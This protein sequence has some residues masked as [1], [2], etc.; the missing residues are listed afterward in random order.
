MITAANQANENQIVINQL[1]IDNTISILKKEYAKECKYMFENDMQY[2]DDEFDEPEFLTLFYAQYPKTVDYFY[3]KIS[4]ELDLYNPLVIDYV[5]WVFSEDKK[6]VEILGH[7]NKVLEYKKSIEELEK[8]KTILP[9]TKVARYKPGFFVL[10]TVGVENR[11]Y[12]GDVNQP[13]IDRVRINT[14]QNIERVTFND[15]YKE[16]LEEELAIKINVDSKFVPLILNGYIEPENI[17][18]VVLEFALQGKSYQQYIFSKAYNKI[19][20][21]LEQLRK[22]GYRCYTI[23]NYYADIYKQFCR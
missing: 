23:T 2:V 1:G 21:Y 16:V 17:K 6:M 18:G 7:L 14:I 15:I 13:W 20:D 8:L 9:K 4:G 5:K 12:I 11:C 3:S 19:C 22:Q 10:S